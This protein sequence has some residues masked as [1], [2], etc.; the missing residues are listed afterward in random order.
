MAQTIYRA[1]TRSGLLLQMPLR[2]LPGLIV[3]DWDETIT[4]KDTILLVAETAYLAKPG[5]T[6]AFSHFTNVYLKAYEDYSREFGPRTSLEQERRFQQGLGPVEATSIDEITRLGLF[7]GTT[8]EQYRS[9]AS[10]VRLREGF[11]EFMRKAAQKNVPVAILSVNWTRHIMEAVLAAHGFAAAQIFV[12]ELD[13]QQGV[14]TGHFDSGICIRTGLDK[15]E[16][17]ERLKKEHGLVVYIG[18]SSTDLFSLLAAEVGVVM[19]GS[20]VGARLEQ[21]GILVTPLSGGSDGGEGGVYSGG[22]SD[23]SRL[24][25]EAEAH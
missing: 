23:V 8:P 12:N 1:L 11:L 3:T 4:M 13:M 10:K 7:K 24:L 18:D 2:R 16:V 9:Q 5:Y 22:W 25:D 6:P 15:L 14:C 17:V 19:E 21:L 20:S